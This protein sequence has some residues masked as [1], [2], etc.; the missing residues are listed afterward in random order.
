M[1]N[2]SPN[3]AMHNR[4]RF[5][6]QSSQHPQI[7]RPSALAHPPLI[8]SK[9]FCSCLQIPP[10]HEAACSLS[11][12]P[13]P[14]T[15]LPPVSANLESSTSQHG[16]LPRPL[17]LHQFRTA[18]RSRTRFLLRAAAAEAGHRLVSA[19]SP[20]LTRSRTKQCRAE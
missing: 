7:K 4:R 2:L 9:R 1:P 13:Q 17:S 14:L 15:H 18:Q 5:F 3:Q 11:L 6:S 8:K 20:C 19:A 12:P 16:R 10:N